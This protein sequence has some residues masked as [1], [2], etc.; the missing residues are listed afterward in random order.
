ML[1]VRLATPADRDE[2]LR[3]VRGLLT[4]LGGNPASPKALFDVFGELVSD[5]DAGFV[6]IA[7]EEGVARAACTASFVTALRAAGRYV[8]IQEMFVEP[9]VRSMGV[10]KEV[11]QFALEHA[12]ASGYQVVELGTPRNGDR[13][14]EFYEREGFSNIGARMRWTTPDNQ[15]R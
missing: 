1:N 9:E 8:I 4:E 5:G 14:I 11:I 6:V 3:L 2:V 7:E 13:Q 15:F 10:G 12:V